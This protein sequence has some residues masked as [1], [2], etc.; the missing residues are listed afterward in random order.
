MENSTKLISF[1]CPECHE[2]SV[3]D[4]DRDARSYPEIQYGDFMECTN[5]HAAFTAEVMNGI[6]NLLGIEEHEFDN[7]PISDGRSLSTTREEDRPA[8]RVE[9]ATDMKYSTL[10]NKLV[11]IT[12]KFMIEEGF[13]ETEVEDYYTVDVSPTT[14][15]DY[16]SVQVR[17]ELDYDD[18]TELARQLNP[19]LSEIEP[20]AYFDMDQP[21]IMTACINSD[22]ITSSTS[23]KS[24][25]GGAFD[26]DPDVFW[27]R[28]ELDELGEEV[29]LRAS[30]RLRYK[31]YGIRARFIL[32]GAYLENDNKTITLEFEDY[33]Q[34]V[35]AISRRIDMRKIRRPSDLITRYADSY[36]D[37]LVEQYKENYDMY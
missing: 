32:T 17:A 16:L 22:E 10:V 8:F 7:D 23:I 37:E 12:K 5:C 25:Y 15:G 11:T 18:M 19:V 27:T 31:G 20:D 35:Y 1:M 13:D 30:N 28:E 34:S 14:D 21:G 29:A 3:I 36:R 4:S 33:E 24:S 2:H 6:V 9:G 26:I